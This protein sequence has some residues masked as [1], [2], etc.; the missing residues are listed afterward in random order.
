MNHAANIEGVKNRHWLKLAKDVLQD[1]QFQSS[2]INSVAHDFTNSAMLLSST[3]VTGPQ[4]MTLFIHEALK[5]PNMP[6]FVIELIQMQ[7]ILT[8]PNV[9]LPELLGHQFQ[10]VPS[11]PVVHP[12]LAHPACAKCSL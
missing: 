11:G 3:K 10:L 5:R 2:L 1:C 12:S 9:H 7:G 4:F 6:K 8:C